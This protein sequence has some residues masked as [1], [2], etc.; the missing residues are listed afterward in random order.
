MVTAT[1]NINVYMYIYYILLCSVCV[2]VDEKIS[3]L[4]GNNNL[5]THLVQEANIVIRKSNYCST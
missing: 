5:L 2:T 4:I 3:H 1:I